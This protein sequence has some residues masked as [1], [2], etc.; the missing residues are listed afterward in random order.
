MSQLNSHDASPRRSDG[1]KIVSEVAPL[2]PRGHAH[3]SCDTLCDLARTAVGTE[4]EFRE[5]GA[6]LHRLFVECVLR[7]DEHA[8]GAA[9]RLGRVA[10]V[11]H[12][13]G[14]H[15]APFV[16]YPLA[17]G[18]SETSRRLRSYLSD[19]DSSPGE[20]LHRVTENL[21]FDE[22]VPELVQN[23]FELFEDVFARASVTALLRGERNYAQSF[24]NASLV[25]RCPDESLLSVPPPESARAA[26]LEQAQC[27]VSCE[28]APLIH[29]SRSVVARAEY[30]NEHKD[31]V[32]LVPMLAAFEEAGH[33]FS[34]L[35]PWRP[36]SYARRTQLVSNLA[37]FCNPELAL[38]FP[39][40]EP[41]LECF[42]ALKFELNCLSPVSPGSLAMF[43]GLFPKLTGSTF[44]SD[45]RKWLKALARQ[46]ELPLAGPS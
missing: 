33:L 11:V 22:C 29:L 23:E 28:L 20:A 1:L 44:F 43:L 10:I 38:E 25:F 18:V 4:E 7:G 24:A 36:L 26:E 16:D 8:P 31:L 41:V 12:R 13:T 35:E 40:A 32:L 21:R 2:I 15:D 5:L 45:A 42:V 39:A 37:P 14:T 46:Y 30:L 9:L 34:V 6:R 19:F 27:A 17:S 3:L